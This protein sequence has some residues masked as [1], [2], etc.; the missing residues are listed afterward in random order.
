M[1]TYLCWYDFVE[2]ANMALNLGE[3]S[4]QIADHAYHLYSEYMLG[5]N[6]G[7]VYPSIARWRKD[8]FSMN[9]AD[10]EAWLRRMI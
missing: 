7:I 10:S 2:W 4:R 6:T 8:L 9:T 1:N 5:K 3:S